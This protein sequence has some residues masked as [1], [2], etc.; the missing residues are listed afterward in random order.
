MLPY[1]RVAVVTREQGQKEAGSQTDW[2]SIE[3]DKTKNIIVRTG[4]SNLKLNGQP[5]RVSEF[6]I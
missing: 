3:F 5:R 6:T 1:T 4:H 2:F